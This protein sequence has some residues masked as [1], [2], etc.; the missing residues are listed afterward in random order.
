MNEKKYVRIKNRKDTYSN[1]TSNNPVLED[2][3]IGI[4]EDGDAT[5]IY[6]GNGSTNFYNLRSDPLYDTAHSKVQQINKWLSSKEVLSPTTAT[7]PALY[8]M[9]S[10]MIGNI[11]V[12]FWTNLIRLERS[13]DGGDSWAEI[14]NETTKR[15]IINPDNRGALAL[16]TSSLDSSMDGKVKLRLTINNLY[17]SSSTQNYWMRVVYGI[18]KY[19]PIYFSAAGQ[20]CSVKLEKQYYSSIPW[21]NGEYSSEIERSWTTLDAAESSWNTVTSQD[22]I[23]VDNEEITLEGQRLYGW[24]D[25]NYLDIAMTFG[26]GGSSQDYTAALRFTFTIDKIQ[27][28]YAPALYYIGGICSLI[29]SSASNYSLKGDKP[30]SLLSSQAQTVQFSHNIDMGT[31]QT[32]NV[33]SFNKITSTNEGDLKTYIGASIDEL[34]P[35]EIGVNADT[36]QGIAIGKGANF[37]HNS[38]YENLYGLDGIAIGVEA[39]AETSIASFN[40]NGGIAIGYQAKAAQNEINIKTNNSTIYVSNEKLEIGNG[41]QNALAIKGNDINIGNTSTLQGINIGARTNDT[42]DPN[43]QG[44]IAIGTETYAGLNGIAIGDNAKANVDSSLPSSIPS[45][46]L[47]LGANATAIGGI[48]IGN[49]IDVANNDEVIIGNGINNKDYAIES[50]DKNWSGLTAI[51][52]GNYLSDNNNMTTVVGSYNSLNGSDY[53]NEETLAEGSSPNSTIIGSC[54][55]VRG[56][57]NTVVG[58]DNQVVP[59]F[60]S[61]D[62]YNIVL[63]NQITL[64]GENSI[65]IGNDITIDLSSGLYRNAIAIG[66]SAKAEHDNTIAIGRESKALNEESI[67]LN[68]AATGRFSIAL[69]GTAT[70]NNAIQLGVGTNNVADSLQ[71]NDYQIARYDNEYYMPPVGKLSQLETT[72]KD[73]IVSAIN[74]IKSDFNDTPIIKY[75]ANSIELFPYYIDDYLLIFS[76]CNYNIYI[77]QTTGEF[78]LLKEN[79]TTLIDLGESLFSNNNTSTL[80]NSLYDRQNDCAYLIYTIEDDS[81]QINNTLFSDISTTFPEALNDET[82]GD[83]NE[84]RILRYIQNNLANH[85]YQ[86]ATTSSV[87]T[88]FKTNYSY[89]Y[90]YSIYST[91]EAICLKAYSDSTSSKISKILLIR[92]ST[93]FM[94]LFEK[95]IIGTILDATTDTLTICEYSSS[96]NYIRQ[97][98]IDW[99]TNT[100]NT[101]EINSNE[102]DI[103]TANIYYGIG[104]AASDDYYYLVYGNSF[105]QINKQTLEKKYINLT[106]ISSYMPSSSTNWFNDSK[107]DFLTTIKKDDIYAIC[108]SSIGIIILSLST[109]K[110]KILNLNKFDSYPLFDSHNIYQFYYDDNYIIIQKQLNPNQS[111]LLYQLDI[112]KHFANWNFNL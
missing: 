34:S 7:E 31:N 6:L 41:L 47:A 102:L 45:G 35:I 27:T 37:N 18:I 80:L 33:N 91:A 89:K 42:Q 107:K 79:E 83:T 3:E 60:L 85:T 70:K 19:F 99:N 76:N 93:Y 65:A 8:T 56:Y 95:S 10:H 75:Q 66:S 2:G 22:T 36:N 11:F 32:V 69:N 104:C 84:E 51:G 98:E 101:L 23:T 53:W 61:D 58:T 49:K 64:T 97:Y 92:R 110:Y 25:M 48:A 9:Q 63:G 30:Y 21:N 1:W 12:D 24:P 86:I 17:R 108:C 111:E 100:V 94:S 78:Y 109:Q 52:A 38:D 59:T 40:G 4:A 73:D 44:G 15:S 105:I 81:P 57:G 90:R 54:Q 67:A 16:S 74:E 112:D 77:H 14:T 13:L 71:F 96:H 72:N 88:F 20:I 62:G 28:T 29:Y 87:I 68:G 55:T 43:T 82:L 26:R 103:S 46:G 50:I 106:T 39:T 5:K